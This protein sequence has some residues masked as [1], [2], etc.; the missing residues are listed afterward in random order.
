MK[1]ILKDAVL[2]NVVPN[3][4]EPLMRLLM[5]KARSMGLKAEKVCKVQ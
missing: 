1:K 2:D 3:E 4:R 5:D